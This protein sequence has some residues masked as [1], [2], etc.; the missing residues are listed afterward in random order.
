MGE[1]YHVSWHSTLT[2]NE[3]TT[4]R[5]RSRSPAI[6]LYKPERPHTLNPWR[7]LSTELRSSLLAPLT[8]IAPWLLKDK[9]F[10]LWVKK[11]YAGINPTTVYPEWYF[12]HKLSNVERNSLLCVLMKMKTEK[13][14]SR[15]ETI[16]WIGDTGTM[17]FYPRGDAMNF[18]Q[19]LSSN[20]Y[21]DWWGA[22]TDSNWNWG[23]RSR[24]RGCQL[25]FRGN[26][27]SRKMQGHI[28]I[29]NPGD[30]G[31]TEVSGRMAE[32]GGAIKHWWEDSGGARKSSHTP[33]KIRT[34]LQKQG[35]VVPYLPSYPVNSA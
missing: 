24:L 25:H 15:V 12:N 35:I 17:D 9:S 30:P 7:C 18:Q 19:Y 27:G 28:D 14:W 2:Y 4:C 34:A 13:L 20:G 32:L 33:E 6:G 1:R 5:S 29:N 10:L 8:G 3:G 22:N 11:Y 26:K 31:K 16:L 23:V 21:G